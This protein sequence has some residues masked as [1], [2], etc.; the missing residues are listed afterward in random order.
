MNGPAASFDARFST[1]LARLMHGAGRGRVMVAARFAAYASLDGGDVVAIVR[2]D[3]DPSPVGVLLDGVDDISRVAPAGAPIDIAPD[4]IR[5]GAVTIRAA[6][7]WSPAQVRQTTP[8]GDAAA[9]LR[10]LRRAVA[11]SDFDAGLLDVVLRR[12]DE[13]AARWALGDE[14]G[15]AASL[16]AILGL[17]PGSTPAGDDAIAGFLIGLRAFAADMTQDAA[18]SRLGAGIAELA[19]SR[20]TTVSAGLLREAACGYC[21]PSLGDA[22]IALGTEFDGTTGDRDARLAGLMDVGHTSGSATAAGLLAAMR[23]ANSAGART[24]GTATAH[25]H[26]RTSW[27]SLM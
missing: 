14:A 20:T 1:R 25:H 4:G 17:G 9:V 8:D 23:C 2:G 27:A 6:D 3:A 10:K 26:E 19:G 12:I 13:A 5:I 24:P 7:W 11:L 15:T 22:V 18:R 16:H 21:T